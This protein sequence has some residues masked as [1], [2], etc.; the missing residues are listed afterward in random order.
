V[1]ILVVVPE[2]GSTRTIP[3]VPPPETHREATATPTTGLRDGQEV[4]VTWTGFLPGKTI[5][6]VQCT[7]AGDGGSATCNLNRGIL[8]R[9][10]PTG[11]GTAGLK[12]VVGP[13]GNG[14]CDATHPCS[15][16]VN[17]AGLQD[18]DAFVYIPVTFAA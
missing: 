3:T 13:V 10:H 17:D 5:N 16:L 8:L 12:V 11:E 14:V 6:I 1:A 18:R 9:P 15:I 2:S 7:G 4:T